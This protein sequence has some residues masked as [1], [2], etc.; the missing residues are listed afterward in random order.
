M[1]GEPLDELYFQWLYSK[2]ADPDIQEKNLTYWGVLRI[3]YTKP[4]VWVDSVVHDED[5]IKDGKALRIEFI[6]DQ[7][8]N[9][10]DVDHSWMEMGCSML[11]LMVGLSRRLE[12]LAD[13]TPH[14]WFWVLMSNIG[15][16]G[17]NDRKRLPRRHI[18]DVLDEI[19]YRNYEPSGLGGFFP[20]QYPREDQRDIDLW[21]Q[22]NEYVLE[23]LERAG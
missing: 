20:L 5:R 7:G 23:F 1:S 2:V 4:F 21:T 22:M 8:W 19:I 12:F 14:Y 6:E 3:L 15:L 17:Y 11:E 18:D 16:A 13:G 10:S 9:I